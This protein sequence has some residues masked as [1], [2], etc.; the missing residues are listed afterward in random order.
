MREPPRLAS[1][2]FLACSVLVLVLATTAS[3]GAPRFRITK[4]VSPHKTTAPHISAAA[5]FDTKRRRVV[6]FGNLAPMGE[7]K[8]PG[9]NT[10]DPAGN[11]FKVI[12]TTGV[13]PSSISY[14]SMVYEPKRDALYLFGGWKPGATSPVDELW[15]LKLGGDGPK[16]WRRLGSREDAPPARNG[17]VMVIDLPRDRLILHGGDGGIHPEYGF[18]PLADLWSYDL[19]LGKWR[20]L[21]P[22]GTPPGPRWNHSAA[23]D[24]DSG[25]MYVFGGSGYTSTLRPVRDRDIFILNLKSLIWTR[26]RCSGECPDSRQGATLTFDDA[27]AVLVLVGGLRISDEGPSG[28]RSV[29]IYDLATSKWSEKEDLDRSSR[30]AHTATYD[31]IGKQHIVHGGQTASVRGNHYEKGKPLYD[32]I[33]ISVTRTK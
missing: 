3:A 12:A 17:C 30:R 7:D 9:L 19:A 8:N 6:V 20:R 4:R 29:W 1:L 26:R 2:R 16:S 24:H 25:K 11:G 22:T 10:Y 32:T 27:V 23:V 31:P 33:L 18:T 14:P 15:M 13:S 28:T 21:S 5:V